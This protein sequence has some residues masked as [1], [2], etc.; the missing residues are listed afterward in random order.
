MAF[1]LDNLK[2]GGTIAGVLAAKNI[3]ILKTRNDSPYLDLLLTDGK[4]IVAGKFWDYQGDRPKGNILYVAATIGSYNGQFQL[5]I[6]YLRPAKPEEYNPR[7][8]LPAAPVPVADLWV[9][10]DALVNQIASPDL[11]AL[12]EYA[13]TKYR[14]SFENAP[15]AVFHHHA[16]LGGCLLHSIRVAEMAAVICDLELDPDLII[17]GGLLHDIGKLVSY[18]WSEGVFS[19]TDEGQFLEHTTLGI[20]T[21]REL[22]KEVHLD[23]LTTLKLLHIIASHHGREE[24]GAPVKPKLP[25][26]LVIHQCDMID[27]Q[28]DKLRGVQN[29]S[30]GSNWEYVQ[31]MGFVYTGD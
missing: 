22:L 17:A 30:Q 24:W 25:E 14:N 9:R 28:V 1:L 4:T 19:Y 10:W 15:G 8:F 21:V 27:S 13:K 31:G 2:E 12:L 11:K 29:N 5:K 23:R 16:Y 3:K 18:N 20:L 6:N 26:A 7:D